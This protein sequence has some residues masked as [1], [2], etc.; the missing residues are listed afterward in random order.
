MNLD[1][2]FEAMPM[3]LSGS[4][5][6]LFNGFPSHLSCCYLGERVWTPTEASGGESLELGGIWPRSESQLQYILICNL[7]QGLLI[8]WPLLSHIP[9]GDNDSPSLFHKAVMRIKWIMHVICSQQHYLRL[10]I[11]FIASHPPLWLHVSLS[12][13]LSSL[14]SC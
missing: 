14:N 7:S 6:H 1:G 3:R 11:N 8:L 10:S 13:V 2:T 12:L 5:T 4:Y 9:D